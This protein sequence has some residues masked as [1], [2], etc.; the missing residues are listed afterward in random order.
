VSGSG[1]AFFPAPGDY[2]YFCSIPGHEQAGMH[3]VVHV[4]GAPTTLAAA[5]QATGNPPLK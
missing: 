5:L 4:S 2:V 3:G 1:V